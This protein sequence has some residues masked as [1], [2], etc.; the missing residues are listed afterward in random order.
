MRHGVAKE[1]PVFTRLGLRRWAICHG[2]VKTEPVGKNLHV[3]W[4]GELRM[5]PDVAQRL[6]FVKTQIRSAERAFMGGGF[7]HATHDELDK[8]Q[9][10]FSSHPVVLTAIK[11]VRFAISDFLTTKIN[12]RLA[13]E[14]GNHHPVAVWHSYHRMEQAIAMVSV[15]GDHGETA[16]RAKNRVTV[17]A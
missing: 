17:A 9:I 8:F 4:L 10:S 5:R 2:S 14:H 7:I 6:E 13:G 1:W 16:Y 12:D 11:D 3:L 15:A